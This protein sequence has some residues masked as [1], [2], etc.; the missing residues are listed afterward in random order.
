MKRSRLIHGSW[1]AVTVALFVVGSQWGKRPAGRDAADTPPTRNRGQKVIVPDGPAGGGPDMAASGSPDGTLPTKSGRTRETKPAGS[2]EIAAADRQLDDEQIRSLVRTATKGSTPVERRM[3]FDR[4]LQQMQSGSFTADQAHVI[5]RAMVEHGASGEQWSLFSYAWG[6][7]DP[8]SAIA[9]L[10]DVPDR[11][12]DSYL[13]NMI[14][15]LASVDPQAAIE[16]FNG[17]EANL[18][19]KIRPRLFEGLIDN[20]VAVATDYIYDATD[21]KGPHDWRPMDI[22]TREIIKEEG[23]ETTLQ[24]AAELPEG[25]LRANAWS[26]AYAVWAKQN[27]QVAIQEIIEMTPSSDRNQA[28]NGFISAYAHENGAGAVAWAAEITQ[29]DMREA[30]MVRAGRQFYQQD[31]QAAAAWLESTN[32][33]ESAWDQVTKPK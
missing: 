21:P 31:P 1:L 7:N 19:A 23:L 26:A 27:P 4:V 13:G 28:I 5:L 16:L 25:S 29:P 11:Y 8:A 2:R 17:L 24:W 3:A 10:E 14:P 30:A 9:H 12:H 18:Q 33:P 15:G 22:L 6:A 20:D 32:L